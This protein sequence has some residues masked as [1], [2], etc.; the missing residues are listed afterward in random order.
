MLDVS[1]VN[2]FWVERIIVVKRK[3]IISNR[4]KYDFL[5]RY[6]DGDL[7]IEFCYDFDIILLRIVL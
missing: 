1:D 5:L 7:G 2:S 6:K 3:E 4:G